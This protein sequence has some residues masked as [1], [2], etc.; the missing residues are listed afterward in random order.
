MVGGRQLGKSSL[1]KAV[2]RRMQGH[3]HTVC[4]YVSLRDHRLAP[5]MA[6]QFG[7]AADTPLEAIVDHLQ[8]Q[9][10]GKRLVL[11]IDEAG[12]RRLP[13]TGHRAPAQAAPGL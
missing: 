11:L 1:L 8:S 5:R 13:R 12:A 7:L 3:P 9:Y 4:H 6:L 10:Q 2:Q